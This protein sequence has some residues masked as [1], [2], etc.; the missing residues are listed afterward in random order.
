MTMRLAVLAF[1]L[2]APVSASA[3]SGLYTAQQAAAGAVF[4]AQDCAA[5]HGTMLQGI[6]GPGLVGQEF[7]SPADHYTIGIVFNN[8]WQGTPAGA[9]DSLSKTT[10]VDIM[11][12][13]MA[14]NGLPAG[15]VALTYQG[16]SISQAP[17]YSMMK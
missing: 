9:P 16:A 6:T 11:A 12:F 17:F 7:A 15:T 2:G 4:Y 3:A 5:C 14:R 10:Y 13:L 8:V 1:L